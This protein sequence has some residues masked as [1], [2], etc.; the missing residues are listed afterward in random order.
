MTSLIPIVI[1]VCSD[2]NISHV[3][4]VLKLE[5]VDTKQSIMNTVR[6][7]LHYLCKSTYSDEEEL[8][9]S[10]IDRKGLLRIVPY[11]RIDM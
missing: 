1:L 6:M 3:Y 5:I 8:K 2:R 4:E 7:S 10:I 11:N 9:K